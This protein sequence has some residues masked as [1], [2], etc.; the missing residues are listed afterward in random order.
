[1]SD[2]SPNNEA[3]LTLSSEGRWMLTLAFR[4]GTPES[5]LARDMAHDDEYHSVARWLRTASWPVSRPC[6]TFQAD[7]VCIL[8]GAEQIRA[9]AQWLVAA[10]DAM[11]LLGGGDHG[12]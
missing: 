1:M 6:V 3:L 11:D 9:I 7:D 12:E 2:P 5:A 4:H 10:A 8:Y